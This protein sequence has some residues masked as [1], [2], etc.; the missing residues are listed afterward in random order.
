MGVADLL[1]PAQTDEA[2][3]VR[4]TVKKAP[5]SLSATLKVVIPSFADDRQYEVRHWMPRGDVLPDV[6]DKAL[7]IFDDD[8]QPWL[9]AFTPS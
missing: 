9:V 4:A 3:A 7:V 6:G 8:G 1:T 5:A 2:V